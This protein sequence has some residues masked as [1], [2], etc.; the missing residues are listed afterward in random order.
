MGGDWP[1]VLC[2]HASV[3]FPTGDWSGIFGSPRWVDWQ[4][5]NGKKVPNEFPWYTTRERCVIFVCHTTENTVAQ[6]LNVE[7]FFLLNT[8]EYTA[9]WLYSDWLCFERL[10]TKQRAWHYFSDVTIFAVCKI[11][12][13]CFLN[14][15]CV[16]YDFFVI[17]VLQ[18]LQMIFDFWK[19]I[20]VRWKTYSSKVLPRL[21]K[22]P[23][24]FST[25]CQNLS[26][27]H[28]VK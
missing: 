14:M 23:C 7:Y 25:C 4:I 24:Y 16:V 6:T 9:A 12:L 22:K 19:G 8:V 17:M 11:F 15:S 21:K 28:S 26:S 2:I 5:G 18:C 13:N 10:V 20:R 1:F 27:S 3:H